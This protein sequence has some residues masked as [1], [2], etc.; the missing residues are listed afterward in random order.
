MA[1]ANNTNAQLGINNYHPRSPFVD[2]HNRSQRWAVMVC[3]RRAGKTVACVADLVLSALTTTKKDARYAYLAPQ[4]NQAKDIA[5]LYIK[6]LTADIP[7]VEYNESEL[8][9]DFPNG[10]RIRLY[11]A[12]NE[13][14]L[15]GLFLDGIILDEYADMAPSVWGEVIR[16][17]LADRKGWAAF[18]GTPKGHN[19]FYEVWSNADADWFKLMLKASESGIIDPEELK[20]AK[21]VQ[22]EDQYEQEFECSFEAAIRG[23][24]YGKEMKAAEEAGRITGVPYE[25]V[26]DVWVSFD[27]GMDDS[28]VLWFA[29][30]VGREVRIIDYYE[31]HG[32][33]LDHYVK[34]M[35]DKPYVYAGYLLPHDAKV[36]ELGTGK[37]RVETFESLGLRNCQVVPQQSVEDGINAVRLLL[38]RCWFDKD[39]CKQGIEALKQYRADFDE[40]RNVYSGRPL[41]DWTSHAADSFRYLALGMK[42]ANKWDEPIKYPKQGRVF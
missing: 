8:R 2:F 30:M 18:I 22:T 28:T 9:A 13:Q 27:L 6:R 5:W 3:H 41:H 1:D 15:R 14:R 4:Y 36:R 33:A 29:Q 11:G 23:A 21:K 10:S 16:P 24:Y 19:A 32:M 39:K 7:G 34:V 20:A 12:E 25:P 40:K 31:A 38:P 17:A 42:P 35:R 26:S 37:S